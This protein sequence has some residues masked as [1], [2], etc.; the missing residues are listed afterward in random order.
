V[1]QEEEEKDETMR[2]ILMYDAIKIEGPKKKI[3][4]FNE[5]LKFLDEKQL[6][7]FDKLCDG[8]GSKDKY[9]SSKVEES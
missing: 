6:K 9:H 8:I 1:A 5:S 3:L 7:F 4:E 2:Q